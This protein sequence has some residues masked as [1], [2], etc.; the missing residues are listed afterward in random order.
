VAQ[1]V[2]VYSDEILSSIGAL[3]A[4]VR[5]REVLFATH[6]FNVNRAGGRNSLGCWEQWL[7]L[8]SQTIYIAVLWPG[9]SAWIPAVDY[10]IEGNEAIVSGNLLA[11]FIMANLL[12]AAAFSFA[13]HSLGARV[14]LQAIR[15]IS[16][17]VR[18]RCL[19]LMAGAI[20]DNCLDNEYVDSSQAVEKIAVLASDHDE[21]LALAFPAGNFFAGIATRGSPYWHA[22]LGREGPQTTLNGKVQWDWNIPDPWRYGHHHYLAQSMPLPAWSRPSLPQYLPPPSPDRP[23]WGDFDEWRAAW[24]AAMLSSFLR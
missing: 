14:V 24:S 18:V 5:N 21:V 3:Q 10:P 8:P 7:S 15:G 23:S 4:A 12:G 20:D 2:A 16:K 13:S 6:G 11:A 19:M 22:A 1:D 9:D 17:A